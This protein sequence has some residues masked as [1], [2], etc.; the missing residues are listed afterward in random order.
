MVQLLGFRKL[1]EAQKA[2]VI[3][4]FHND[5]GAGRSFW[6]SLRAFREVQKAI[7][8]WDAETAEPSLDSGNFPQKG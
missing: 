2:S 4:D 1:S 3:A 8:L 5:T 6:T 7:P